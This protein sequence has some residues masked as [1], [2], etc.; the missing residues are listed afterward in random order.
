MAAAPP[1]SSDDLAL[2]ERLLLTIQD[3]APGLLDLIAQ[4]LDAR[5]RRGK[6][7]TSED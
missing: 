4:A 5:K 7:L 1:N 6:T 3:E 2:G